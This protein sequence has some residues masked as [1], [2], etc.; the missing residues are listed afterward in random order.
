MNWH[1]PV[2]WIHTATLREAVEG[3][4]V[5]KPSTY[6]LANRAQDEDPSESHILAHVH[7]VNNVNSGFPGFVGHHLANRQEAAEEPPVAANDT[8]VFVGHA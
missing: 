5:I 8:Y 4:W 1:A 3:F 7:A 6:T 2:C